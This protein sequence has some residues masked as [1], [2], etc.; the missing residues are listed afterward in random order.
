MDWRMDKVQKAARQSARRLTDLLTRP[1]G[2]GE[3]T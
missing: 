1:V 2:T 3:T